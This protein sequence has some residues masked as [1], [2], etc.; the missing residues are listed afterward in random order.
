M[1][2][3]QL[4]DLTFSFNTSIKTDIIL[5]VLD[6]CPN[7]VRAWVCAKLVLL[8]AG[9]DRIALSH[10]CTLHIHSM[11]AADHGASFFDCVLTPALKGTMLGGDVNIRWTQADFTAFQLWTPNIARLELNY[12]YLTSDD[13]RA[14]L[15]HTSSFNS[16]K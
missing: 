6:Q 13:L 3:G 14:A 10:L 11:G 1:P 16:L 8:G 9:R 4:V 12:S 7:L 2:C 5:D 15:R